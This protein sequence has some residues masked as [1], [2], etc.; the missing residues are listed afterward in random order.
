MRVKCNRKKRSQNRK[1]FCNEVIY[2]LRI[3][4]KTWRKTKT[5]GAL[6]TAP[7]NDKRAWQNI[8]VQKTRGFLIFS[9]SSFLAL[10]L[11]VGNNRQP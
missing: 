8:L 11:L 2:T 7:R 1:K 3:L 6:H 4:I 10:L 5:K 9:S